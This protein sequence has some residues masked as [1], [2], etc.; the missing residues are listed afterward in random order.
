MNSAN[1]GVE[2]DRGPRNWLARLAADLAADR[3]AD[4]RRWGDID[5]ITLA[6]YD[7]GE[8]TEEERAQVKQAMRDFPAVREAMHLAQQ[9]PLE[10]GTTAL[11]PAMRRPIHIAIIGA[12]CGIAH[13]ILL[14][15]SLIQ[16]LWATEA[17]RRNGSLC[18]TLMSAFGF[19]ATVQFLRGRSAKP[20]MLAISLWTIIDLISM[21]GLPLERA[22]I[23]EPDRIVRPGGPNLSDNA[24]P[25]MIRPF[26]ERLDVGQI[27]LGTILA[28]ICAMLLFYLMSAQVKRYFHSQ[29][30]G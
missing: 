9:F 24:V 3:E 19:Y 6:R 17:L 20:L 5:E 14:Q 21:I 1:D 28:L 30:G 4:R 11:P 29:S 10:W 13:V 8:C 26:E 2:S 22:M 27:Q 16:S 12:L 18:L 25:G 7:A 23:D 15:F